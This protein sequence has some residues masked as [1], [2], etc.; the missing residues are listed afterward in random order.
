VTA[1]VGPVTTPDKLLT[2]DAS[3]WPARD[4]TAAVTQWRAARHA[5][6]EEHGW[7]TSQETRLLEELHV[8]GQVLS[9][10]LAACTT[11]EQSGE[12]LAAY[13]VEHGS[14]LRRLRDEMW[15]QSLRSS[16]IRAA[17]APA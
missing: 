4:E 17:Q 1:P 15:Q 14:D 10:R 5:W 12:A 9:R 6:S 3:Q 8:A 7:H 13:Q 11:E 16:S 2:F